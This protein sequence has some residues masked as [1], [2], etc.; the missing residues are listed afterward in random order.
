MNHSPQRLRRFCPAKINLCLTVGPRRE[1]G[2]HELFSV[3]APVAFGDYLTVERLPEKGRIELTVRGWA[4][5]ADSTNLVWQAAE[6]FW[7]EVSPE[8][9]VRFI[10][11]KKIPPGAGLGGGSSNGTQAL[12]AMEKLFG[13]TLSDS[14]RLSMA[15]S[16]GSDCPLFL[17]PGPVAF[18]GRGDILESLPSSFRESLRGQSVLLAK[19]AFSVG[20]AWAFQAW[21][22][23]RATEAAGEISPQA[24]RED[25]LAEWDHYH[26]WEELPA[27]DLEQVVGEKFIALPALRQELHR[28]LG[29]TWQ[30]SGSGSAGFVRLPE[31]L[32]EDTLARA[33]QLILHAWGEDAFVCVTSLL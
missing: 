26:T 6:R 22:S 21:Q 28:S 33:R 10:L 20:T 18:F 29:W 5:P 14:V 13:V 23:R 19:P 4:A 24:W 25:R 32:D 12:L 16:L 15:A 11:E 3:V 27:N 9:G 30:M 1:D 8:G 31:N 7:Q 2:F 17:A